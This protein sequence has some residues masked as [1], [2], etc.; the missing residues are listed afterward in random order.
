MPDRDQ[1]TKVLASTERR[2]GQ[3]IATSLRTLEPGIAPRRSRPPRALLGVDRLSGGSG[4]VNSDDVGGVPIE[5]DSG[6]V[7]AHRGSRVGVR[8]GFL[9]VA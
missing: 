2:T 1:R 7:I 9:D 5:R 8:G 4:E 6:S 3:H